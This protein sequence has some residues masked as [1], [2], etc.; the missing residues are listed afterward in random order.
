MCREDIYSADEAVQAV[1]NMVHQLAPNGDLTMAAH[2]L[3]QVRA[4]ALSNTHCT[5]DIA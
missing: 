1:A 4:S 3:E 5:V 2:A